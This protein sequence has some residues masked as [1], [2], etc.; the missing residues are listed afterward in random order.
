[1]ISRAE[2]AP[3]APPAAAGNNDRVATLT[4]NEI[5]RARGYW[6]GLPDG[7]TA[8]HPS[9]AAAIAAVARFRAAAAADKTGSI[10]AA[11]PAAAGPFAGREDRVSP[12]LA[13]AYAEQPDRG[14]AAPAVTATPIAAIPITRRGRG[15]RGARADRR[16]RHHHRRQARRRPAGFRSF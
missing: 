5:I 4:P 16:Q 3:L 1:M 6:Q 10:A 13:L 8:A 15:A 7:M 2:A 12:A 9:A 14:D 11:D